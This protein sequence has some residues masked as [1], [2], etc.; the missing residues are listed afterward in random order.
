MPPT[1]PAMPP[2]AGRSTTKRNSTSPPSFPAGDL[3][4]LPRSPVMKSLLRAELSCALLV[5]CAAALLG[6]S[7]AT[8]RS[9]GPDQRRQAR[10]AQLSR[11]RQA[12]HGWL[13]RT[14]PAETRTLNRAYA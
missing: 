11:L 13:A 7:P 3:G 5:P 12:A 14:T 1:A 8:L 10:A 9:Q 2:P 4:R 6:I